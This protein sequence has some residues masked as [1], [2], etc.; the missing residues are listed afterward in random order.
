MQAVEIERRKARSVQLTGALE[1]LFE[2][3]A[4]RGGLTHLVL[5]DQSGLMHAGVGVTR[6]CE[7]L[8]SYAPMVERA[9][10]PNVRRQVFDAMAAAVPGLNR[11]TTTIR[12]IEILGETLY[13]CAIG[14][15][16][17]MKDVAVTHALAGARRILA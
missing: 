1:L 16:G 2:T 5:A 7:A 3:T 17:A 6:E 14:A 13:V 10:E 8:A 15:P 11:E 4:R 9:A 12:R